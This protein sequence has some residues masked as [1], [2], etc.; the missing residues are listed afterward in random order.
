MYAV[1]CSLVFRLLFLSLSLFPFCSSP[2][3]SSFHIYFISLHFIMPAFVCVCA[4]HISRIECYHL[5]ILRAVNKIS[6][7]SRKIKNKKNKNA[8]YQLVEKYTTPEERRREEKKKHSL[9]HTQRPSRANENRANN[10]RSTLFFIVEKTQLYV[11]ISMR[12]RARER[13][14][15]RARATK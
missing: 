4:A 8:K 11:W 9:E 1:Q 15:E 6:S 2:P 10:Q 13:E 14:K 7:I 12:G 5:G 3:L